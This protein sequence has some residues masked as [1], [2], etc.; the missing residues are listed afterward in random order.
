MIT[1]LMIS[2]RKAANSQGSGWSM[3][4][5]TNHGP[6]RE[7]YSMQFVRNRAVSNTRDDYTLVSPISP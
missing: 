3:G 4:E 2:L 7:V 6:G 5:S 1:R